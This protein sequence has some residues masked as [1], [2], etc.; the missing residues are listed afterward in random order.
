MKAVTATKFYGTLLYNFY[1][2]SV[3]T[4]V[5]NAII[6]WITVR[7]ESFSLVLFRTLISSDGGFYLSQ[8]TLH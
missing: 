6:R 3:S 5:Q 7:N 2:Q 8:N 4:S 1:T